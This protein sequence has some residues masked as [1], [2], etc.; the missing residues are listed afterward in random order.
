[1][2]WSRQHVVWHIGAHKTGT[3]FS[4]AI[5]EANKE[6][7]GQAGVVAPARLIEADGLVEFSRVF[8]KGPRGY[9]NAAGRRLFKRWKGSPHLI[10]SDENFMGDPIEVRSRKM[11]WK[12]PFMAQRIE[13]LASKRNTQTIILS[14]RQYDD[15]FR[16]AYSEAVKFTEFFEFEEVRSG[17]AMESF[18]WVDLVDELLKVNVSAQLEIVEFD[19]FRKNLTTYL[20]LFLPEPS[21]AEKLDV[22]VTRYPGYSEDGLAFLRENPVPVPGRLQQLHSE[23]CGKP[24]QT[25]YKPFSSDEIEVMRDRYQADLEKITALAKLHPERLR[26]HR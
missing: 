23:Y 4:Q 8:R 17:G 15:F 7:L 6:V 18:S 20:G 1:M 24:G 14:I 12:F 22:N 25:A 19:W 9:V 10:L 26:F 21:L 13:S 11:Y 16:S 2:W 3:T 5:F